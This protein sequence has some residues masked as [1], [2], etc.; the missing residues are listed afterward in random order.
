MLQFTPVFSQWQ[1]L[2]TA[3]SLGLSQNG[4]T[5]STGGNYSILLGFQKNGGVPSQF[6]Q[7]DQVVFDITTTQ[8]NTS[9]SSLDFAFKSVPGTAG[10]FYSAALIKQTSDKNDNSSDWAGSTTFT[11]ISVPEP[12]SGW[13]AAGMCL[14]ALGL[15]LRKGK[16]SLVGLLLG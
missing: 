9:L 7:G 5:A 2:S 4:E 6:N 13:A 14:A 10:S 16:A 15:G 11:F 12:V 8:A 3:Y 1:G